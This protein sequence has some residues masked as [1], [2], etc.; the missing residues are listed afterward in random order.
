MLEIKNLTK[1]YGKNLILMDVN[2][3]VNRGEVL[4][5]SGP[6][7]VGK[8]TLLKCIAGLEKFEAGHIILNNQL[9]QSNKIY[10]PSFKRKIGMVF[11]D[12][13]LWPH[14]TIW[15]NVDF[16][17]ST[18]FK[19]KI[20][21]EN[22]NNELLSQFKIEHKKSFY[23]SELSGG[24]QQR[25][26]IARTLANRPQMFLLDEPF[27]QLDNILTQ[28]IIKALEEHIIKYNLTTILITHESCRFNNLSIRYIQLP[29]HT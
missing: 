5:I 15:K 26:V 29:T 21:R 7:G 8:T 6:S 3:T 19:S 27:N 16:V 12:L 13:V 1:Y 10:V 20:E 22:W 23:P 4:L 17:S 14:M 18:L 11:Q 2:L 24:E 25:A 9:V 28:E